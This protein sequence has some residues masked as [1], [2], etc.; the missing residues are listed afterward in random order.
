MLDSTQL[1]VE[2]S[3]VLFL[4]L[5]RV[6]PMTKCRIRTWAVVSGDK[7]THGFS[8]GPHKV[9]TRR[10]SSEALRDQRITEHKKDAKKS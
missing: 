5:G 4:V 3:Q 2:E 6:Q 10:Y 7:V 8:C 9:W 1:V